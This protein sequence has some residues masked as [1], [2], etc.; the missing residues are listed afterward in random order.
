MSINYYAITPGT[1]P[2]EEG[3]HIGKHSGG[4]EFLFRAHPDRGLTTVATWTE[5]LTAPDVVIRDEHGRTETAEEFLAWAIRRPAT[6]PEPMRAHAG[7]HISYRDE[8]GAAF[9]D[10][11]FC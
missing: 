7:H 4:W 9:L 11:A 10:H 6:S 5:L 8:G 3:L 1:D 2:A